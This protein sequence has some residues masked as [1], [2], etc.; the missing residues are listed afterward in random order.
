MGILGGGFYFHNLSIPVIA[1]NPEPKN[2]NRDLFFGY[3]LVCITYLMFGVVGYLGFMGQSYD[4]Y[5]DENNDIN[6]NAL[7]M[8][9]IKNVGANIVR[10]CVFAHLVTVNAVLFAFERSQ[11]ILL[12]T[13]KTESD[14]YAINITL[15]LLLM[16][17]AFLLSVYYPNVGVL[18]GKLGAFATALVIYA[19]PTITFWV[20]KYQK[21][22][23]DERHPNFI[24]GPDDHKLQ[25]RSK[26]KRTPAETSMRSIKI[27]EF[28]LSEDK[29][30][31]GKPKTASTLNES[32]HL[33]ETPKDELD[34][35]E[36][37]KRVSKPTTV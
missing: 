28:D 16:T 3:S 26:S 18:A 13:G 25:G 31:P 17:P 27:R 19:V 14:S 34:M 2:N 12:C 8:F 10:F 21:Y 29:I 1:K 33:G 6:Q 36:F 4:D 15:N 30:D 35:A 22:R 9:A 32:N 23:S 7:N 24:E 11:I 5:R 37:N 20:M